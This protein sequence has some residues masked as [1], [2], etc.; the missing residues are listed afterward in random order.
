MLIV[1]F[2]RAQHHESNMLEAVSLQA[3]RRIAQFSAESLTLMLRSLAFFGMGDSGLFTRAVA[4]LPR[5]I[6][7]FRPADVTTLLST[8]AAAQVHSE[9]LFDIVTP[10]ILEK[11][12]MFTPIDWV[13]A[14]RSFSA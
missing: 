10:F 6:I 12:P 2:A 3:Q 13:S 9:A 1:A 8:F 4:Q 5:M 7:T 11:A 14:L